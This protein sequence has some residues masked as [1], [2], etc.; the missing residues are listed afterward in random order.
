ME[1]GKPR[2]L[3]RS[4]VI[5]LALLQPG[6]PSTPPL[7]R[8]LVRQGSDRAP[9]RLC[10]SHVAPYKSYGKHQEGGGLPQVHWDQDQRPWAFSG[11]SVSWGFM[12][13]IKQETPPTPPPRPCIAPGEDA[14]PPVCAGA[15]RGS[16]AHEAQ[17]SPPAEGGW[18]QPSWTWGK[19]RNL[20]A[21]SGQVGKGKALGSPRSGHP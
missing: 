2:Y 7:S 20:A 9:T 13:K 3:E 10:T 8:S 11:D 1:E 5:S 17:T 19:T 6:H 14:S 21:L 12:Q 15:S 16:N 4:L 18:V